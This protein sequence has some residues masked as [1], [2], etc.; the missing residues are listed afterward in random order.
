MLAASERRLTT[1]RA[2]GLCD[3]ATPH[4]GLS[5]NIGT[6]MVNIIHTARVWA[7]CCNHAPRLMKKAGIVQDTNNAAPA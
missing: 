4:R 6:L 3:D 5:T 2:L 1:S 7:R